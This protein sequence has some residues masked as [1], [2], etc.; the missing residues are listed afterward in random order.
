MQ[1]IF[2]RTKEEEEEPCYCLRQEDEHTHFY[3]FV[4]RYP[5]LCFLMSEAVINT[6]SY[7]FKCEWHDPQADILR[8]YSLTLY[9]QPPKS[10]SPNEVQMFDIKSK[11]TFLRRTPIEN[12]ALSDMVVGGSVTI[13]ARIL[14]ITGYTDQRT[15]EILT[16]KRQILTITMN[17]A[18][19]ELAGS[20]FS[21]VAM[22]GLA[23]SKCRLIDSNGPT[24]V[25]EIVG[26]N[27]SEVME[28]TCSS[29]SW[30][31]YA[32]VDLA[33]QVCLKIMALFLCLLFLIV[34][35]WLLLLNR[36]LCTLHS[37]MPDIV[38]PRSFAFIC[39][40]THVFLIRVDIQ[41][42]RPTTIVRCALFDHTQ[43]KQVMLEIL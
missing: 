9:V 34:G 24:I 23:I 41:K 22:A 35:C 33:S 36:S 27:A 10:S 18:G 7:G 3:F 2:Q 20:L 42:L 32:T 4:C 13:F 17:A 1:A 11:R 12:L 6:E 19:Y 8:Y 28:K 15:K 39:R 29:M 43:S 5:P 25:T 30:W 26:D 16:S 21:G 38:F 31:K 40:V 37:R 14:K